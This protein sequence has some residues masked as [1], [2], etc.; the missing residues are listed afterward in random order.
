MDTTS[1]AY[2]TAANER[3]WQA[4]VKLL[5]TIAFSILY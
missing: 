5:N 1:V 3:R 2:I 4:G